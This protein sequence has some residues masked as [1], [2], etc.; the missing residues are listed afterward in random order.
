VTTKKLSYGVAGLTR[1]VRGYHG[2]LRSPL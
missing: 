1:E 2:Q